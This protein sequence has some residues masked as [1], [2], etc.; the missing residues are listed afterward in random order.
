MPDTRTLAAIAPLLPRVAV[1]PKTGQVLVKRA[2]SAV[3]VGQAVN[4][5]GIVNRSKA[6]FIQ[7][8]SWT[9]KEAV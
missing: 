8:A 7:S 6:A 5:D 4:P 3:D 1:D 9:L 2:V